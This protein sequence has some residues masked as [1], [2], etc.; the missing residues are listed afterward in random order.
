MEIRNQ[1]FK[2]SFRGYNTDEVN[3]FLYQIAQDYESLYS[4]N[5]QLKD[6]IQNVKHELEKYKKME[7]AVN[8]SLVLAQQAAETY[9]E[10]AHKEVE[11]FLQQS[12]KQISDILMIYQETIKRFNVMSTELKGNLLAELEMMEKNHKKIEQMSNFFYSED[13][14]IITENLNKVTLENVENAKTE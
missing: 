6:N 9:S 12:K 13:M 11:I 4:E 5:S 3:K 7:D 1:S 10:N 14:K 8:N 2:K